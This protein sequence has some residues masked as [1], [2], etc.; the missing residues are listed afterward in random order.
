MTIIIIKKLAHDKDINSVS[1]SPNDRFIATGL[2]DKTDKV[3]FEKLNYSADQLL[4][5]GSLT[6]S[7]K[8]PL[9]DPILRQCISL[10]FMHKEENNMKMDLREM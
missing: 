1:V 3:S 5:D 4:S 7:Q 2:Q 10:Q 8:P 9:L 6:C